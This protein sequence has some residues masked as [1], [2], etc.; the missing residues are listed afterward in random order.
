MMRALH[1]G[2]LCVVLVGVVACGPCRESGVTLDEAADAETCEAFAAQVR[3]TLAAFERHVTL[4]G[5][6]AENIA[7]KLTREEWR[8]RVHPSPEVQAASFWHRPVSGE[9]RKTWG[10][11][12]PASRLLVIANF[13]FPLVLPHELAHA[14]I[15][16]PPT[17]DPHAG[18]AASGIYA[19]IG[20]ATQLG[21][22][23]QALTGA[24]GGE[25]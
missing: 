8:V 21:R 18:W 1:M 12:F 13:D 2:A 25:R 7:R 14:A 6:S 9:C 3:D 4:S 11:A 19:A 20:D 17:V 22:A 24:Q 15:G 10:E 23:R 5:W 16:Q